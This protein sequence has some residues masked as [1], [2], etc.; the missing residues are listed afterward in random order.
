MNPES[1]DPEPPP[2]HEHEPTESSTHV[3]AEAR[4]GLHVHP[5]KGTDGTWAAMGR[6]FDETLRSAR[7]LWKVA[8][9]PFQDPLYSRLRPILLVM[10]VVYEK[11]LRDQPDD[12]VAA[13]YVQEIRKFLG[14]KAR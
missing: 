3:H 13:L 7:Q 9:H 11:A 4:P 10:E 1:F 6:D 2:C 5:P 14:R 8:R 12:G